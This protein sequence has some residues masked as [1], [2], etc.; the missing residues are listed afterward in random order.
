[1]LKSIKWSALFLSVVYIVAGVCYF[2]Y[3]E[4]THNYI[5]EAVGG[6]CAA[7][8]LIHIISYFV[9]NIRRALF[10]NDFVE[11]SV[12][13]LIGILI[14]WQKNAFLQ[15]IPSILAVAIV[16]SGIS[17]IQDGIDSARLGH[18]RRWLE[19]I[20]ALICIGVGVV[21]LMNVIRD[22]A[23]MFKVIAGGLIFSGL[24]DLYSSIA[25]STKIHAF[26]KAEKEAEDAAKAEEERK[27]A[28]QQ[29]PE[30]KPVLPEE[31]EE[32]SLVLPDD[33][34]RP[35][36]FANTLIDPEE[37]KPEVPAETEAPQETEVPAEE[38]EVVKEEEKNA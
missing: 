34:P 7:A 20:L 3:P 21:V 17:K 31:E 4:L 15:L 18:P 30:E 8:G 36:V 37:E 16:I 35:S 5:C 25:L 24:T 26:F 13:V 38:P 33:T 22:E 9:M 1:M 29:K 11:G 14:A 32:I 12:M 23:L 6:A 10:E 27:W 2:V 28:E 19:L